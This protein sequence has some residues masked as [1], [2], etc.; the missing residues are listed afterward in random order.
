MTRAAATEVTTAARDES[1]EKVALADPGCVTSGGN[2]Q[3]ET[4]PVFVA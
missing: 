1:L 4:S 2:A 3:H